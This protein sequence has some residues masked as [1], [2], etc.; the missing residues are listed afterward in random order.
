MFNQDQIKEMA[1]AIVQAVHPMAVIL[2]G[3]YARGDMRDDSDVDLLVI[4][5]ESFS[6]KRSRWGELRTIRGALRPFKGPKDILVFSKEEA[7]RLRGSLNH[8]V[9]E[10]FREGKVLY[11]A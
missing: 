7:D 4:E 6:R 2:F 5:R 8:V 11:E 3:S 9:G 10:A 1:S